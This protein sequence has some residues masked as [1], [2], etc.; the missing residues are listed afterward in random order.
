MTSVRFVRFDGSKE[1]E[2]RAWDMKTC[3]I[4]TL[5]EWAESLESNVTQGI[6][7]NTTDKN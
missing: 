2:W 4:G 3:A 5:N 1:D 6:A 7:K